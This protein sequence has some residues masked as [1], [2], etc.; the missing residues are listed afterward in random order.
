MIFTSQ[1][2]GQTSFTWYFAN[3]AG[4]KFNSD[5]S[6]VPATGSYMNTSEGCTVM[7]DTAGIIMFYSD[8]LSVWNNSSSTPVCTTLLGGQSSTQAALAVAIPGSDCQRFLIF[9]TKGS[10]QSGT[11]DLGVALINV[12]GTPPNYAV[13]VSEPPLSVLQ[14]P[15]AVV[16]GEKLAATSD[17][18]GGY[19]VVAHDY[20]SG[21]G[22][23][24]T[25]YKYHITAAA[26]SSV[27]TTAQAQAVLMSVQQTQSIGSNHNN[28]T[29]PNFNAQ[30]QMKFSKTGQK[31][32]L[33]MAGSKTINL[34]HFDLATGNITTIASTN[35]TPSNGNLYGCEFSP[36]GNVLYTSEGFA[37]S[38]ATIR[39]LY[40]W[41]IIGGTLSNPY[42]V[43]SGSNQFS[44]KY[45]YNAL[46]LGPNDKIYCSEEIG[47]S[48]LSVIGNPNNLENACGWSSMS[49]PIAGTN[50]LGLSTVI[51]NFGCS[52]LSAPGAITGTSDV[53]P[54]DTGKI[55]SVSAVQG[56]AGYTWSV[57]PGVIITSG[58]NTNTIA[59][60]FT[61]TAVSGSFSVYAFNAWCI[62]VNSPFFPVAVHSLPVV[63]LGGDSTVCQGQT[64]TFD[65][66]MCP[67]CSYSW[68]DVT[69]GL[70]VGTAQTYTTGLAGEYMAT[71]TNA[72]GCHSA[73]TVQLF[74]ITLPVETNDPLSKSI[75]S[76]E[77]T[78]IGLT[79]NVSNATF[80]WTASGSS[81][82]VSGYAAGGGD[83]I[84]QLLTNTNNV[85]ET[86][87]YL[88]TPF[89]GNCAGN[90]V[91]YVV[92]VVPLKTVNVSVSASATTVCQGTPVTFTA[93]PVNGG[94][95]PIYQ[96][97]INGINAGTNN[98]VYSYSPVNN[99]VITCM[100]TSDVACPA[101]NP[102]TSNPVTMTVNPVLPASVTIAASANPVCAGTS[103]TFTATPVY[104][105]TSPQFQWKVNG[106]N[107]G[108]NSLLYS[109]IPLN[110]DMVWCVMTSNLMCVSGSPAASDKIIMVSS[111]VPVV[112]FTRCFDSITTLNAKPIKLK[113]G[114]P[115]G[116]TYSGSGVNS[117]TGVFT[118]SVAGIG[119]KTLTYT[120]TNVAMCSANKAMTIVV[121]SAPAFTCGNN[122]TDIRDGKVYPTV[123]FSSQCWMA[124]N[125]NYGNRVPSTEHQRDNCTPEKYCYN[126]LTANCEQRGANY[127]WDELM[128]YDDTPGLQG[129]CLPGWHI[130]TEVDWNT[131]FT[132]WTNNGFSG[133]PLK[134]SG[135]SGFN[136]LLSGVRHM[137]VQWDYQDFA[138]FFWSSTPH[139]VYKAWAHGMNDYDPSV[140]AYPALRSNAFSIRCTKD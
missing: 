18:T 28:L 112:T 20:I 129:L 121:Q 15:G 103:V 86:V 12:T 84:N 92:T 95:N 70:Q 43:A 38:G 37:S 48:F 60:K 136:A 98:S 24:N 97:R 132:N 62:S 80:S 25:F 51:S 26:F 10:E 71:I 68:K 96:W 53:C 2:I 118:P 6:T 3:Q 29:P 8:G 108:T 93:T 79:A 82:Y 107:A 9:T 23:A 32:G 69:T 137:N 17:T 115:L 56:A 78:N 44:N 7:A 81:P 64:V 1:I 110:G 139:G 33:V 40:Q 59:V 125:L 99:D 5:G 100:L 13:N 122:L 22:T 101:G 91:S 134:Y 61:G 140:A 124:S 127:Q 47:I 88:I 135:Y 63:S 72:N 109:Y 111:P 4:I 76:G 42:T 39:K 35:V 104:G 114:I 126:E 52:C 128:R 31:L 73:D 55:Y 83:T 75:C 105:G 27:N 30:G 117:T 65:A 131:L 36:N 14:P 123:Q 106:F 94:L 66:G 19:W 21:S 74:S 133:A 77:F 46:Q 120:Y 130:P 34:F 89:T 87:T 45:K 49:E 11:H 50:T 113:G 67:G 119:T 102:A 85:N 90:A 54:G 41:D 16:F 57:P 138:T 58:N 116:G